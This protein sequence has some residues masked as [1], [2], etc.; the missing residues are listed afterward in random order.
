MVHP[1]AGGLTTSGH[2]PPPIG[3]TSTPVIDETTG[4][5]HVLALES[6]SKLTSPETSPW[7]P[8]LC[9]HN[10]NL[11]IAWKGDG[12]DNLNVAQV[13]ITGSTLSGLINKVTLG[14]TSPLSPALAS[15]NGRLYVA[16]KGDGNDNLNVMYS[17]DNGHTF[18]NKFTS[19]ETSPQPP[20]L[21]EH[22]GHLYIGWIGDGNDNLNVARVQISGSSITGFGNKVT[23][24]DTS[25]LSPALASLNG[26]LY[27]AWKGDGNDNLNVRYS[28]DNGHTFGNKNTSPETSP[29]APGLCAH[30]GN[31]Y[32][33]WKG[34]GND[35]LDGA[36]VRT[37][38][39]A[40]T[41]LGSKVTLDDTSPLS[42]SL[43]SLN[44]QLYI[45]WKG[46]GNDN[47][48]VVGL[49]DYH[50]NVLNVN[51]GQVVQTRVLA[52]VGGSG[53]PAFNGILQDQR[54]GLNLVHGWVYA[55]FADFLAF[56]AGDYHGGAGWS[57]GRPAVPP[58][59]SFS[60]QQ[61]MFSGA[62]LGDLA[63]RPPRRITRCIVATGNGIT[64]DAY[65]QSIDGGNLL[66]NKFTSGETSP[67]PPA[68]CAHNGNL[69]IGWK[70]DGNDN[71][72]VAQVQLSGDKVTGFTNKVTL[73]DTSPMSPTLASLGGRLYIGWK[74]DGN[75][76][77]N[78]MYS[79]RQR[80]HIWTQV[81]VAGNKPADARPVR[82]S[83]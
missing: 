78:V 12:N 81:H 49:P 16:W 80:T 9:A 45:G 20:T 69:Y 60:Q 7:A 50:V 54:G 74:G 19:G 5:M 56:D 42:P 37:S 48:N 34:D 62:E 39:N 36:L 51:T 13:Q 70:G 47:L 29:Q 52:D 68:L 6:A 40:I 63:D 71:L 57:V 73:G 44:G 27:I 66:G 33:T 64:N 76:N 11:Y 79:A 65:W 31:L 43:A 72:N 4:R 2:I 1:V 8:A 75:D 10:G 24:G 53:R 83:W 35:N 18:G 28:A 17:A 22:N 30:N 32:N 25:P 3:I 14:D 21:C 82:A 55:T 38:G 23:L 67:R 59:K 46:D 15:L 61:E 26:R 77:L 58:I 41:G